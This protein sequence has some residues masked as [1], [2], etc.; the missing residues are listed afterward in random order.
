MVKEILMDGHTG[1][2]FCLNA[3]LMVMS[4]FIFR[5]L[6]SLFHQ[7]PDSLFSVPNREY[8]LASE[9][10]Q[11]AVLLITDHLPLF[12]NGAL[13]FFAVVAQLSFRQTSTTCFACLQRRCGV[14]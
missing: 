9:R 8:W 6:P 11:E 4:I 1:S 13:I 5:I 7:F 2:L 12:G 14:W 3:G 10:R